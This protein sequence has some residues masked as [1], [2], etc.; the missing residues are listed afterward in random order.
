MQSQRKSQSHPDSQRLHTISSLCPDVLATLQAHRLEFFNVFHLNLADAAMQACCFLF[1]YFSGFFFLRLVTLPRVI[2]QS[3][4]FEVT[5]GQS[6][7]SVFVLAVSSRRKE[8]TLVVISKR[9][10]CELCSPP[11]FWNICS[12]LFI[13]KEKSDRSKPADETFAFS[14]CRISCVVRKQERS[15]GPRS[16]PGPA[17]CVSNTLQKDIES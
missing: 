1:F 9:E 4:M 13:L 17:A 2:F 10:Q 5:T 7:R 3:K 6:S 11:H 14:S 16:M 15:K 8:Q 12:I